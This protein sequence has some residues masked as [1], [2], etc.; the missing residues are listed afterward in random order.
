[1][2]ISEM[3]CAL[4]IGIIVYLWIAWHIQKKRNHLVRL[5]KSAD[6]VNLGSTYAYYDFEYKNLGIEGYNLA[7]IPQYFDVDNILLKKYGKRLK[8]GTKVLF[9]VPD[10]V[11]AANRTNMKRKVYYEALYPWE[12]DQYDIRFFIRLLWKAA[13]E[14]VTHFYQKE[15]K[16][17][18]GHIA[19]VEEKEHH[20]KKR[21]YD[22]EHNLGI[23]SIKS[24]EMTEQL[25]KNITE[26]EKTLIDMILYC[27]NK[28]LEP[29]LVVPPVSGMM[30]KSVSMQCLKVYLYDPLSRVKEHTGVK[31]LDYMNS[32]EFDD[33]GLYLNSDCMNETGRGMFMKRLVGDLMKKGE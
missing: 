23:P 13:A 5:K 4:L 32:D 17:W 1:M 20:L 21:I 26:N 9:C 24:G 31:V 28:G 10:F 3:F 11:F 15:E 25:Y 18:E 6:M 22:W 7:N 33:L 27:E 14:P 16:K 2:K 12:I 30:K 8:A 19:S 29:V